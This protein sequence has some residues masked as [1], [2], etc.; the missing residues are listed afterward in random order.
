MA[1]VLDANDLDGNDVALVDDFTR[2]VYAAV[3][4]LRD[5]DEAFDGPLQA[6]EGA[7]GGELGH[8]AGNDLAF[9]V[10][11]NDFFPTL[12]LGAAD[13]KGDLLAFVVD[14][15]DEDGD[16]IAHGEHLVRGF[17]GALPGELRE[18]DEAVGAADVHEDAE[19]ADAGDCAGLDV[20]FLKLVQ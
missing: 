14:L 3:D 4:E 16:L 6:D 2:V 8:L 7:E 15:E 18:M 19:V 9:P 20:A 5:V 11:G 1:V 12:G 17:G 13:A 10:V